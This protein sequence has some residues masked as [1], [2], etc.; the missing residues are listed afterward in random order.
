MNHEWTPIDTNTGEPPSTTNGTKTLLQFCA[1]GVTMSC[2]GGL[3]GAR[4]SRP[5]KAWHSL[6]HLP[7]LD[8]PAAAPWLSFEL[9]DA[10]RPHRVAACRIARNLSGGHRDRMRAGRPRSQAKADA[11][12]SGRRPTS[13]RAG[14]HPL[15][16]SRSPASRAP[17]RLCPHAK[18]QISLGSPALFST[19]PQDGGATI[20]AGSI[21][22][23]VGT[24]FPLTGMAF[25]QP[26]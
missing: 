21:L 23:R 2:D 19:G 11:V 13:Q 1:L 14:V 12:G 4:A 24:T 16:N 18:I 9:A 22:Y 25:R 5:H 3:L 15:G 7:H 6:D 17:A 10:V 20:P 26:T 8:R